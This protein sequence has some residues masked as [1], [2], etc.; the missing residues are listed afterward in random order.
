[1]CSISL[2]YSLTNKHIHFHD[3]HNKPFA[4]GATG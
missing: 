1:M 3:K 2:F 4:R